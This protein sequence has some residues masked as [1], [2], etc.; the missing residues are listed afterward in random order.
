MLEIWNVKL[1]WEAPTTSDV[2][3]R[4]NRVEEAGRAMKAKIM[5][6][7]VMIVWRGMVLN[8]NQIDMSI[9]L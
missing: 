3:V 8:S 6:M 2:E 7:I 1:V 9:D 4:F 5:V